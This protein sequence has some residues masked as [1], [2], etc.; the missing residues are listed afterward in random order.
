MVQGNAE[1]T[2][3]E[4]G[5]GGTVGVRGAL[6]SSPSGAIG[7]A[8]TETRSA[9]DVACMQ[10]VRFGHFNVAWL[11]SHVGNSVGI[12]TSSR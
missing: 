7:L 8:Q 6:I 11:L 3:I 12:T 9:L 2:Q 10:R 1:G 5:G 4:I